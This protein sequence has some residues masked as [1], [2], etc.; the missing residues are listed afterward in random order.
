MT[1]IRERLPWQRLVAEKLDVWIVGIATWTH[2]AIGMLSVEKEDLTRQRNDNTGRLNEARE[3]ARRHQPSFELSPMLVAVVALATMLGFVVA[4]AWVE[5]N[6]SSFVP[7][8]MIASIVFAMVEI[9]VAGLVGRCVGA[10]VLDRPGSPN[11]LDPVRRTTNFMFTVVLGAALLGVTTL[12]ASAR[13]VF[14]LWLCVGLAVNAIGVYLG[15]ALY[16][17]RHALEVA[18][19]ER[20]DHVLERLIDEVEDAIAEV[21]RAAMGQAQT[22]RGTVRGILERATLA[23]ERRWMRLRHD[24]PLP[25][26]PVIDLPDDNELARRLFSEHV[27]DSASDQTARDEGDGD[28]DETGPP[29]TPEPSPRGPMSGSTGAMPSYTVSYDATPRRRPRESPPTSTST[30][31]TR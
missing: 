6:V 23:F 25:T 14:P 21:K 24:E 7:V 2:S 15:I 26:L 16:D 28:E 31:S 4:W 30:S 22:L 5:R 3:R 10:L 11:E 29:A 1:T 19:R 20:L 13:G 18:W 12:F 8:T 27:Q 17:H 9:V